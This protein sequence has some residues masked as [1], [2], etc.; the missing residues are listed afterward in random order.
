MTVPVTIHLSVGQ[1]E[2]VKI[3]E[4]KKR[5]GQSQQASFKIPPE[6]WES[7]HLVRVV[8]RPFTVCICVCVFAYN[9]VYVCVCVCPLALTNHYSKSKYM[10]T[11]NKGSPN[12]SRLHLSAKLNPL[13]AIL[14]HEFLSK[15]LEESELELL[16]IDWEHTSDKKISMGNILQ[17][18]STYQLHTSDYTV[19]Y[20]I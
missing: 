7:V 13:N 11:S 19:L 14:A 18:H 2:K 16:I 3:E 17:F 6:F 9:F 4:G 15:Q 20:I 8:L 12:E 1:T 5:E 10:P